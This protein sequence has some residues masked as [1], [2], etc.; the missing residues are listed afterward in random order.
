MGFSGGKSYGTIGRQAVTAFS[1]QWQAAPFTPTHDKAFYQGIT[2]YEA[3]AKQNVLLPTAVHLVRGREY[4]GNLHFDRNGHFSMQL[5]RG[6]RSWGSSV[7]V[8]DGS[9]WDP[10]KWPLT[11]GTVATQMGNDEPESVVYLINGCYSGT[12][13]DRLGNAIV[14]KNEPN[15]P[16]RLSAYDQ[17]YFGLAEKKKFA[18]LSTD[19]AN[20]RPI[21]PIDPSNTSYGAAWW[22]ARENV[23]ITPPNIFA[24]RQNLQKRR[25]YLGEDLM[26]GHDDTTLEL[27]CAP[28]RLDEAKEALEWLSIHPGIKGNGSTAQ[29]VAITGGGGLNQVVYGTQTNTAVGRAKP[30]PIR[31][32]REDLWCLVEKGG[33]DAA[34]YRAFGVA[35]GGSMG[36]YALNEDYA[37]PENNSVPHIYAKEYGPNSALWDGL[38]DGSKYGDVGMFW[39]MNQGVWCLSPIRFEFN[40][41][42]SAS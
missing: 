27:W 21:N 26:F 12:P 1:S 29:Q 8:I 33:P 16:P 3:N 40:F 25:T 37:A 23:G 6:K 34:E 35:H 41:V 4:A 13:Q 24:A 10:T 18:V 20:H 15:T 11:P 31:N 42:G 14:L 5:G 30:V 28:T 36:E 19:T 17:G 9:E 32:M 2:H 39:I 38:I 7:N 22:N